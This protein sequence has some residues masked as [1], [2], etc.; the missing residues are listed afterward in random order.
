MSTTNDIINNL[1][2]FS[3]TPTDIQLP[4][5]QQLEDFLSDRELV[6]PTNPIVFLLDASA[7]AASASIVKSESVVRQLYPK[8][9]H[10]EEHLYNHMSDLDYIGRFS[11]PSRGNVNVLIPMLLLKKYA[12]ALTADTNVR[13]VQFPANTVLTINGIK[14]GIHYPIRVNLYSDDVIRVLHDTSYYTE[15]EAIQTNII[16]NTTVTLRGLNYLQFTMPVHQFSVV[17]EIYPMDSV[18]DLTQDI[19]FLDDFYYAKVYIDNGVEW[20]PVKTTHSVKV[21]DNSKTTAILKVYDQT[22]NIKLPEIYIESNQTGVS[23]RIDVYTT[24][25]L[26]NYDLT[27]L[28]PSS[29]HVRWKELDKYADKRG[30]NALNSLS[31]MV[32]FSESMVSGGSSKK[33]L[34]EFREQVIYHSNATNVPIRPSDIIVGMKGLGYDVS[35]YRDT[36]TNRMYLATK[37]LPVRERN[38]L[39][40]PIK[41]SVHQLTVDCVKGTPTTG[42]HKNTILRHFRER[43]TIT[44]E[45]IFR[46]SGGNANALSDGEINALNAMDEIGRIGELN[47]TRYYYSP[48]HTVLDYSSSVVLARAY[49]LKQPVSTKRVFKEANTVLDYAIATTKLSVRLVGNKYIITVDSTIPTGN[50]DVLCQLKYRSPSTDSVGYI[51]GVA[52]YNGPSATFVFEMETSFDIDKSDRIEIKNLL[53]STYIPT[54]IFLEIDAKLQVYYM[55]N[56]SPAGFETMFDGETLPLISGNP[57]IMAT[58]E[59]AYISFGKRMNNLYTY[60]RELV[61]PKTYMTYTADVRAVFEQPVYEIDPATLLRTYTINAGVITY[62][63]LHAVGDDAVDEDG[64]PVFSHLEGDFIRDT[65]GELVI[66]ANAVGQLLIETNIFLM[67]AKYK[68][69]NSVNAVDYRESIPKHLIGFLDNEIVPNSALL[70]ERTELLYA[71]RGSIGNVSVDFGD[72]QLG[73]IHNE[74]TFS[75]TFYMT[76]TNIISN[77]LIDNVVYTVRQIIAKHIL[78][79]IISIADISSDISDANLD[80]VSF[81]M[82]SFGNGKAVIQLNGNKDSFSIRENIVRLADGTLDVVDAVSIAFKTL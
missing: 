27:P 9:A 65:E 79:N 36:I 49:Y 19:G 47:E 15:L 53:S 5:L 58:K 7:T 43:T 70:N 44:D 29:Y 30:S 81:D 67:D 78:K 35:K 75:L 16:A 62:N 3:R 48:L 72:N 4:A 82:A 23:I 50:T 25:G 61:V 59:E 41:S 6:D 45:A 80:V 37:P 42:T 12:I 33:T 21:F 17:S 8:M 26:L 32:F 51:D 1:A 28:P 22:L 52:T 18:T 39:T 64:N 77:D 73:D 14:F 55:V 71:P 68:Y 20:M 66:D 24:K 11:T 13:S 31:D 46:V 69:A 74:L 63:E 56:G 38:G 54:P 76:K 40:V 57:V 2:V 34:E 60:S 10:T